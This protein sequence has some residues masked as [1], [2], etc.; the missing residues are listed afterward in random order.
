MKTARVLTVD[1]LRHRA[2][3]NLPKAIFEF[4]DGGA[5]DE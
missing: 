5:N 3:K 1:D 2:R 4:I